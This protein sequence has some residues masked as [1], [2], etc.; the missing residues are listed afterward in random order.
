MNTNNTTELE[1]EARREK[2]LTGLFGNGRTWRASWSAD[3]RLSASQLSKAFYA[4]Q[5][6]EAIIAITVRSQS[7]PNS[8]IDAHGNVKQEVFTLTDSIVQYLNYSDHKLFFNET[9]IMGENPTIVLCRY[10]PE[11]IPALAKTHTAGYYS[12]SMANIKNIVDVIEVTEYK[13]KD[14]DEKQAEIMEELN[15]KT[16]E[17][18]KAYESYVI[19]TIVEVV[20]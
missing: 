5:S 18:K 1:K 12:S 4:L 3:Y 13:K 16:V 19:D 2:V 14:L 15:M 9:T 20:A 6:D 17:G 10:K 7:H 11:Y 8:R